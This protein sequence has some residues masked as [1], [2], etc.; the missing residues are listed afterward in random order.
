MYHTGLLTTTQTCFERYD[1]SHIK[2]WVNNVTYRSGRDG[3]DL[4]KSLLGWPI[5]ECEC[6]AAT[7]LFQPRLSDNATQPVG[8]LSRV[9]SRKRKKK[10]KRE[11]EQEREREKE[12]RKRKS[13]FE[14][15]VKKLMTYVKP[16]LQAPYVTPRGAH[17]AHEFPTLHCVVGQRVRRD[18]DTHR[19]LQTH[20]W[21]SYVG[22]QEEYK[23]STVMKV[24]DA[25]FA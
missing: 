21:I 15:Q 11:R 25:L 8:E 10:R 23:P 14:I 24:R 6:F 4:T 18:P 5:D 1:V 12:R 2:M 3:L 7:I 19:S 22:L 13:F 20:S 9:P 17:M 16:S